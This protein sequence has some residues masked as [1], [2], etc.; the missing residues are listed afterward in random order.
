MQVGNCLRGAAA[1]HA[2]VRFLCLAG[3]VPTKLS[4]CGDNPVHTSASLSLPATPKSTASEVVFRQVDYKLA[5]SDP[6]FVEND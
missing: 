4:R 6:L 3:Y 1:P 5:R 2:A